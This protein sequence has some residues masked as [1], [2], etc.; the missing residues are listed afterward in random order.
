M[1]THRPTAQ[2]SL[3][4][5]TG[6]VLVGIVTI[7]TIPFASNRPFFWA[8]W[9]C[10]IGAWAAIYLLIH[11]AGSLQV[12]PGI[13]G[14]GVFWVLFCIAIALQLVPVGPLVGPVEFQS[15]ARHTFH[16]SYPSLTPSAT[17]LALMRAVSYGLFLFLVVQ[18][19]RNGHRRRRI[20]RA[21]FFIIGLHALYGLLALTQ[22]GDTI[23]FLE[24]WSYEGSATGTFLNRNSFA[25]FLAMGLVLGIGLL[26]SGISEAGTRSAAYRPSFDA[27]SLLVLA[28]FCLIA[29]ALLATQSRMGVF[30]ATCGVSFAGALGVRKLRAAGGSFMGLSLVFSVVGIAVL[31]AY[32]AGLFSRIGIAGESAAGRGAL[33]SQIF[34]MI[35]AR[36]WTGFGG[37]SFELAYPLFHEL[38]VPTDMVWDKAHSTYLSL[39]AE[40]GI[41]AGSLP[42]VAFAAIAAYSFARAV[43]SKDNWLEPTVAT[44]V[45]IVAAVHSIVDFSLE[46]QANTLLL[47]LLIGLAITPSRI[48][49]EKETP[50]DRVH[51]KCAVDIVTTTMGD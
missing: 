18:V 51:V 41:V 29:A 4:D 31:F 40:Y 39:W 26:L 47:L 14:P 15:A 12:P 35:S 36:P 43:S 8:L 23:L 44:G 5:W 7:A 46:I 21:I 42:L 49:K 38:P 30:S 10:I 50:R 34:T 3:N 16:S 9:A 13:R 19:S 17:L 11:R 32:G 6:M 28:V 22:F 24:K 1:N 48:R 2:L 33:Y 25:T 45:L 20:L 27:G 37:G